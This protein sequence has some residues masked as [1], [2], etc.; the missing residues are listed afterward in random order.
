MGSETKK[1]Q[2]ALLLALELL[3][4][5]VQTMMRTGSAIA[6]RSSGGGAF[7][8][9]QSICAIPL[10]RFGQMEAQSLERIRYQSLNI[11]LIEV[12]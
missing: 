3:G 6:R 11:R 1:S 7:T 2:Q 5:P 12:M 4:S 10:I 8:C 9:Q